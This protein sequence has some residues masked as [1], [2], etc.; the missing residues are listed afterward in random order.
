MNEKIAYI[1]SVELLEVVPGKKEATK[2]IEDLNKKYKD[3]LLVMQNDYNKKYSDFITYQ[4]SMAEAIKLRRMQELTELEKNVNDFMKVAQTDIDT[5]EQQMIV[6]LRQKLQEVIEQVGRDYGFVCIYDRAN[7]A[8]VFIT[9]MAFDANP[10]V[11]RRLLGVTDKPVNT[12]A[13]PARTTNTTTVNDSV[14]VNRD[15]VQ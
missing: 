4:S 1:N 5:Q 12:T 10:L 15:S 14:P 3:E 13:V 7:P 9:P 8:L 11:K 6:P 2:K